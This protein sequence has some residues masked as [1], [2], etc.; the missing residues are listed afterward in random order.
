MVQD[1]VHLASDHGKT[2]I[3]PAFG[4]QTLE[5]GLFNSQ[6]ADGI[7]G[8][9][10]SGGYG[11]TLHDTIV[12]EKG[13]HNV[14]SMCLS[15]TVGALV[16]GATINEARLPA[17]T[18]WIPFTS[19]SAYNVGVSDFRIDGVTAGSPSSVYVSTIVDS[20]TT[21]TYL[22]PAPYY[23]A[24]DR[25]RSVC[26]WGACSER[27]VKGQYPDDYCYRMGHQELVKFANYSFAFTNGAVLNVPSTQYAYEWKEGVWCMGVYN[28]EHNG[29]VIGG[30]TMRNHEVIF[31]RESHRVAFVPRDCGAMARGAERSVL[32]D[33]YGLAGCAAPSAPDSPPM[34]PSSPP[35]PFPP[36]PSPPPPPPPSPSPSP[37]APPH[38]PPSPPLSPPPPLPPLPPAHPPGWHTPPPPPPAPTVGGTLSGWLSAVT[39]WVGMTVSTAKSRFFGGPS[40]A[41]QSVVTIALTVVGVCVCCIGCI[42]W[43]A[44]RLLFEDDETHDQDAMAKL[45]AVR[46]DEDERRVGGVSSS[47]SSSNGYG[48]GGGGGAGGSGG[49]YAAD[50]GHGASGFGIP[51][52]P[53]CALSQQM[54]ASRPKVRWLPLRRS[55]AS[56]VG[57]GA[58]G[59]YSRAGCEESNPL[60]P[61][62]Y[63]IESSDEEG[64][65]VDDNGAHDTL[66]PLSRLGYGEGG[67]GSGMGYGGGG[68]GGGGSGSEALGS[69]VVRVDVPEGGEQVFR[70]VVPSGAQIVVPLPDGTRAGDAVEFELQPE[71]L[72]ELPRSDVVALH[73]GRYYA[74]P[75][76]GEQ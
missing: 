11:R 73:D 16:L 70:L 72:A 44:M 31:D 48:G 76:D 30:A 36:P 63:E 19:T 61:A 66:P 69:V 22:P 58:H 26:P 17:A 41:G 2:S 32:S 52:H 62:R 18:K 45:R 5:T 27:V 21:F 14:F 43:Y 7:V 25:W 13:V 12:A 53:L 57:G 20:G 35:A 29:A 28:N 74:E 40:G 4:C 50:A 60:S 3:K 54:A 34:P 46:G 1:E 33:G 15:E 51:R 55:A 37:P 75:G 24:R 49:V 67:P 56:G 8:F 39:G 23:K 10:P 47:S 68:G 6:V 59:G 65:G 71:Q 38:A 9:S 42:L 64:N